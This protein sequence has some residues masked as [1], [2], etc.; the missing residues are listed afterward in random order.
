VTL[1]QVAGARAGGFEVN[2]HAVAVEVLVACVQQRGAVSLA[3]A[4][5]GGGKDREG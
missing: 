2:G 4:A 5:V 1:V 3:L